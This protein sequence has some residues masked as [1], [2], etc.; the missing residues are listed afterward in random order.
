[1][2]AREYEGIEERIHAAE[3]KLA[4][5]QAALQDPVVTSDAP[6][7]Q[8]VYSEMQAAQAEV[9]RLFERWSE[10]ETKLTL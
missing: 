2:E 4:E 10:L 8:K 1:M 5:L 9:D 6:R 7:L 3:A